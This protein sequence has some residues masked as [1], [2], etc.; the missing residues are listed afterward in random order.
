MPTAQ[1]VFDKVRTHLENLPARAVDHEGGQCQYRTYVPIEG[2][3]VEL[4]CAIGVLLP[5]GEWLN[6][7][8]SV[9]GL[10]HAYP[11]L[12]TTIEPLDAEMVDRNWDHGYESDGLAL[13]AELQSVH[14]TGSNWH[15]W[16]KTFVGRDALKRLADK[17]GLEYTVE[18][19]EA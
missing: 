14:D 9:E 13:L 12:R 8:G 6:F 3:M 19:E 2:K 1:E 18:T 5:D 17:F 4:R 10:L 11:Q 16:E 15:W 7:A